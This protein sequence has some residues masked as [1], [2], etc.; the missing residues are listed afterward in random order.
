M[1]PTLTHLQSK[2]LVGILT[3]TRN[4]NEAKPRA[5]KLPELWGR[6]YEE[7]VF[8]KIPGNRIRLPGIQRFRV[9]PPFTSLDL[10]GLFRPYT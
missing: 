8:Q 7:G 1:L 5:P 3:R 4:Q 10:S 2:V 6:F 9:I